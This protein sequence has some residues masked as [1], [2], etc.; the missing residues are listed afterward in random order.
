MF[1]CT[2]NHQFHYD[3]EPNIGEAHTKHRKRKF[4]LR[5]FSVKNHSQKLHFHLKPQQISVKTAHQA[6]TNKS[7]ITSPNQVTGGHNIVVDR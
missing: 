2:C 6:D 4:W 3:C 1:E 7:G 5:K